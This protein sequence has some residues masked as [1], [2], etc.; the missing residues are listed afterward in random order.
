MKR[1]YCLWLLLMLSVPPGMAQ[2]TY[3]DRS[4]LASGSWFKI[5]TGGPGVYRV[6]AALLASLGMSLPV[7]SNTIRLYG[8]GGRM[9]PEQN[10]IARP[11][12]LLENAIWVDDG[13]DGQFNGQDYFLFYAPGP[14]RWFPD[15]Q[16]GQLRHE[17]NLYSRSG[18]YFISA[19]GEGLR[20][21]RQPDP[22]PAQLV[23]DRFEDY[24]FH[25]LDSLNFLS[26]GRQWY[27]EEFGTGPGQ[28]PSR[29]FTLP[30]AGLIPGTPV[31][32]VSDVI[33]RS[34]GNPGRMDLRLGNEL[35]YTHTLQP[36]QGTLYE[37]VATESRLAAT[38]ALAENR[39]QLTFSFS[40]GA[41]NGQGWLNW[42]EVRCTRLLDMAGLTQLHFRS[43]ATAGQ[44]V[45]YR[46]QNPPNGLRTW[47]VTDPLRPRELF[48]ETGA[49]GI[50][51][52]QREDGPREYLGFGASGYLVPRAVGRVLNQDLHRPVT[53][54]MIIIAHGT[55]LEEARRLAEHHRQADGL[56][57]I[58]ADVEQVYNEF[59]SGSPDPVALRDFVKMF[60]D[61]AGTDSSRRPRYLLL[62]GDASFDYSNRLPGNT[63]IV[64]GWQSPV[65]LDP[66]N[67]YTS[68]DFFG[69]L[70]DQDDINTLVPVPFLDI[71]IGRMPAGSPEQA[72]VMVDKVI[73]YRSAAAKGP[74][75]TQF[76]LVADD[77]D[78]NI[79][80]NDAELHAETAGLLA[81]YLNIQKTY[82]DAFPQESG[83]GGSR[84]PAVNESINSR[85]F[86]GTLIWNY[87]GHGSSQRLA[88]EAILDQDMVRSWR[89]DTKL[90][91]FITA[92][93]DFAP[94]DNP[95][96][97]SI[98]EQILMRQAS[99]AIALM[100][101]TRL[102]FAFSNRIMNN[103]YLRFLLA[104][105]AGGRYLSLGDAVRRSKNFT[106][107][108]SS[109]IVNNRKFTL[110]GDP[111]LTL[112]FPVDRVRITTINAIPVAAFTDTLRALNRYTIAGEVVDAAGNPLPGFQGFVYPSVY[113]KAQRQQTLGNDPG[114]PVAAFDIRQNLLYNGKV[115]ARDG[116]FSFTFIVPKDINY[117]S[118]RGKLSFYA[119]DGNREAAGFDGGMFI[120]GLGNGVPDDGAGPAIRAWLNDEKFVNGGLTNE[121]PVLILSLADSSGINTVGTGIG[122]NLTAVLDGNAA[123]T[124]VLNDFYEA[125]EDSYQRGKVRFQLPVL[126][127][128]LHSLKVRAWDVFNNPAEVVLEFRVAKREALEIR[129]VLNY[130]NPFTTR[131]QFWFEHNRPS[132]DLQVTVQVMTVSGKLVKTIAKTINTGGNRSC[133]VEWDGRDDYGGKL[134]RGVYIYRLRVRTMD[135][136]SQEKLEKLL[137]L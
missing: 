55:L 93:C 23:P 92:T 120:G 68:D 46:L 47:D 69:Y 84:Y 125:E 74:W 64:P 94:F 67:T 11:D 20:V 134:G 89:N 108:S 19:G 85:I 62:F 42:F 7:S 97:E 110:L 81:P 29:V 80:L 50:R 52:R 117:Q 105:D 5:S 104:P 70:D 16:T 73:R 96:V 61:R 9:L 15:P 22:G 90:P 39:L 18:F 33:G 118:G 66:L 88:Q 100:T 13:G 3:A 60:Y 99:G 101:T 63:N 45:E 123:R 114:S 130:P 12:D 75:R 51:F 121:T 107:Q 112:G 127:D 137:I 6:D 77:E 27:G 2:R 103:N 65:S 126:E 43:S 31:T 95:L 135:G 82:L 32:V 14:D 40:P 56:V 4:V 116:R 106:Y 133:E 78:Q 36:L 25:E 37:P 122:H 41:V 28:Q 83:T 53:V 124:F 98:G 1:V 30:L 102:V 59:A 86:N 109:D 72:R 35:F 129:H 115:R 10:A 24:Y 76:S 57:S 58:V 131:T 8:N 34:V 113:D 136:K 48:S 128:G 21:E 26:S 132:E 17:S 54:G 87:S 119:D 49:Q 44:V 79:H 71:G 91:L 38:A 111:A